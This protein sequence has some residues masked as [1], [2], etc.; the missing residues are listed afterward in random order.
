MIWQTQLRGELYVDSS[1]L[2]IYI[3][4][5]ISEQYNSDE[6]HPWVKFPEYTVFRHKN[7]RKWFALIMDIPKSKIGLSGN[8]KI[9]VLDVKC[10]PVL[11]GSLLNEKGFFPAYH[12]SKSNWITIALDGS[13][14]NEKI[15]WLIDMSYELTASNKKR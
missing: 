9:N 7:N 12:M 1:K 5:Y 2:K 8:E 6:E 3:Y 4:I 15:K 11:I 13:V 14:D 10:D